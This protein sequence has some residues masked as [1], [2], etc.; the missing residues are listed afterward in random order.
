MATAL[1]AGVPQ[2][3]SIKPEVLHEDR[4]RTSPTL[5]S[6]PVHFP[7]R[8]ETS[9]K[10]ETIG[11]SLSWRRELDR[12]CA[13]EVRYITT[14]IAI[15]IFV[16]VLPA[17]LMMAYLIFNPDAFTYDITPQKDFSSWSPGKLP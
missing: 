13:D 16:L 9:Q 3:P 7:S 10:K 15:M 11:Q 6:R 8:N 12:V 5:E 17:L 1:I 14:M 4:R 2:T